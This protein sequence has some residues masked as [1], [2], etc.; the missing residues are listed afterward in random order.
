LTSSGTG[1]EQILDEPVVGDAEDRRLL[2]L[3]D[4]DDDLGVL[5]PGQVLDRAADAGGDVELRRDDL[6]GLPTCQSFGA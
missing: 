3:V 2:V 1:D 4:R 6:A 5:H